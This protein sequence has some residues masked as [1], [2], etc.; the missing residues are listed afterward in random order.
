MGLLTSVFGRHCVQIFPRADPCVVELQRPTSASPLVL[1]VLEV[2]GSHARATA[3]L[4]ES[5]HATSRARASPRLE[6]EVVTPQTPALSDQAAA[7]RC[8]ESM[9]MARDSNRPLQAPR[10]TLTPP[11]K[12][13]VPTIEALNAVLT[14]TANLAQKIVSMRASGTQLPGSSNAW[15][16]TL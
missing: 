8:T 2:S 10:I 3:P 16:S 5:S 14:P 12:P 11:T 9:R 7:R 15:F 6:C 1:R 13:T 4:H